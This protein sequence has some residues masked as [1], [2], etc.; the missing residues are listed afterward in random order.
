MK[1]VIPALS[2]L[3][4][5]IFF[6]TA[7]NRSAEEA[8]HVQPQIDSLRLRMNDLYKP[9]IGELMTGIQLHHAKLWFAGQNNNW[10]LAAYN[11]SLIQ[12]GFKKIQLYHGDKFEAKAASMIDLPMDS[13]NGAIRQKDIR[14]FERAFIFLTNTCNNCH[15]V[16]LHAYNLITVPT[17]LPVSN[18]DFKVSL[19]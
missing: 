2:A 8:Q 17:S 10:P 7:C 13:V 9:G 6:L 16:T 15:K 1:S 5:A 11:A 12:G 14:S 4:L 3:F 18:Q 19:K